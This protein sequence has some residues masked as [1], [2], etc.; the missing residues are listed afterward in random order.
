MRSFCVL[1]LLCWLCLRIAMGAAIQELNAAVVISTATMNSSTLH[2]N[3]TQQSLFCYFLKPFMNRFSSFW[4][5]SSLG[6][7]S[8]IIYFSPF[9]P[10]ALFFVSFTLVLL[11]WITNRFG[12]LMH[13]TIQHPS[14]LSLF[15]THVQNGNIHPHILKTLYFHSWKCIIDTLIPMLHLFCGFSIDLPV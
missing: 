14:N 3:K 5:I 8:P 1:V 13:N 10:N 2:H 7:I 12:W 15:Q 11:I 9:S 6:F 4:F